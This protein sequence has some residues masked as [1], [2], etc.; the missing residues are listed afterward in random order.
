MPNII[1]A[2][3]NDRWK[4]NKRKISLF[5]NVPIDCVIENRTIPVLYEA[6]LMLE[7]SGLSDIVCRELNLDCPAPDMSEWMQLLSRVRSC[8]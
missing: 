4:M 3:C 2:R 7:Q 5:C 8:R 1:I 6:P